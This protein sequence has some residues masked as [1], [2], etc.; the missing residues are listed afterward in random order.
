MLSVLSDFI[1]GIPNLT[2]DGVFGPATRAAVIAAQRRFGLPQTG[3]VDFQ[4]WDEIYDQYA[5]IE[6]TAFRDIT[7]FPYTSAV[8]GV[9]NPRN[10]Y[11]ATSTMGQFPG[12]N[13]RTGN[14]DPVRQEV[15]R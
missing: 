14:Q 6:N 2:I 1:P 8:A 9:T 7:D 12:R 3:A 4:T 5:G 15:V 10:R 11:A 13:L